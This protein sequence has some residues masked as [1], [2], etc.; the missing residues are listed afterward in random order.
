MHALFP[1][2]VGV[3]G[4]TLPRINTTF[5]FPLYIRLHFMLGFLFQSMA[6]SHNDML[7]VTIEERA[8]YQA[9]LSKNI[10]PPAC[11]VPVPLFPVRG[12]MLCAGVLGQVALLGWTYG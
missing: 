8:T 4:Q 2:V 12:V 9:V 11:C 7:S 5:L 10:G 3:N 6:V 1:L